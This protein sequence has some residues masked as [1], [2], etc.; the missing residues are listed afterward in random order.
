MADLIM[1]LIARRPRGGT[2][3]YWLKSLLG[4]LLSPVLTLTEDRDAAVVI[5][6][7]HSGR[8]HILQ[9]TG[10]YAQAMRARNR[11]QR[12]LDAIGETAFCRRYGLAE[13]TG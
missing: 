12:E 4:S 10:T 2:V 1:E 6:R 7:A 8:E 11:F 5:A 3:G 13:T 9:R